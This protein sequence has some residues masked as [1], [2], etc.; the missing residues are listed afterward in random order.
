MSM[1]DRF[2][3]AVDV[4]DPSVPKA[5]KPS[6]VSALGAF[7]AK[8]AAPSLA[9]AE[10]GAL[11]ARGD[12]KGALAAGLQAMQP[13][14]G[15]GTI[16]GLV[17]MSRMLRGTQNKIPTKNLAKAAGQSLRSFPGVYIPS[18][19]DMSGK[20]RTQTQTDMSGDKG[21]M[22]LAGLG[23]FALPKFR[24]ALNRIRPP[25]IR[26]GTVGRRSAPS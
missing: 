8:Q 5:G 14:L 21:E 16:A 24:G 9:G 10:A 1:G 26:G 22:E 13:G 19:D 7:A 6:L 12:K 18:M 15:I 20:K 3:R 11:L 25:V 23:A 4:V 17:S 2:R